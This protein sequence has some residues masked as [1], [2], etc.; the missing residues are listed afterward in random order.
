MQKFTARLQNVIK[1][2]I[3]DENTKTDIILRSHSNYMDA[4]M[5]PP[6]I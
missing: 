4:M 3:K 2:D 6:T 1:A 5:S